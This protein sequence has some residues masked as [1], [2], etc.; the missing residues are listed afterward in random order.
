MLT[1]QP[2]TD[3][4][5]PVATTELGEARDA[6]GALT[7]DEEEVQPLA[8]SA[9][10]L[11][12]VDVGLRL[13][14]RAVRAPGEKPGHL[15]ARAQLQEV[16]RVVG[17]TGYLLGGD[18]A[19]FGAWPAETLSALRNL[20]AATWL[21]GNVDRWTARIKPPDD[22]GLARAIEDCRGALGD[23]LSDWLGTLDE[24]TVQSGAR[25]CHASPASDMSSFLPEPESGEADLLRD[26]SDRRVVFGHTHLQFRRMRP[27]GIELINPGSVGMPLDG[28]PRAAYA[29]LHPDGL[30]EPRRVGY[31]HQASAA[32]VRER[33]GEAEWALRSE[34]RLRF[35]QP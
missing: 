23:D 8:A 16:S 31:D 22:A 32:A 26:V 19:L 13:L 25:F 18:Y 14:D 24:Q 20:E 10:S 15:G 28:D 7:P 2:G 11:Q 4:G 9:F 34:R 21:R 29:L 30:I 27:D 1:T 17:A 6:D 3:H 35:S 12:T 33:F 5:P